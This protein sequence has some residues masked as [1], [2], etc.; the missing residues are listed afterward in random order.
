MLRIAYLF[1]M[2]REKTR[3]LIAEIGGPS[4]IAGLLQISS[5]AVSQW[6]KVP[7]ERAMQIEKKSDGVIT[8]AY[9]RP[10][11][12]NEINVKAS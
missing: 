4:V 1:F 5:Q 10:D 8:A 12:F 6:K 9:L 11:I 3:K 2:D 7:L